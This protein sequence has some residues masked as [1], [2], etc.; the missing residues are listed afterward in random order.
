M[1]AA[2][3]VVARTKKFAADHKVAIAVV[4]TTTVCFAI[5]RV[6]MKQHNDFLKEHDLY[7][8]FYRSESYE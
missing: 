7:D 6:A 4:A 3:L 5:N 8:E 2:K 1:N